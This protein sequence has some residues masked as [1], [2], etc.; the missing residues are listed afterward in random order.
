[1]R[2]HVHAPRF[3][4]GLLVGLDRPAEAAGHAGV[5]DEDV[6]PPA[7]LDGLRDQ[8]P[9]AALAAGVELDGEAVD[10]GGDRRR[11]VDVAVGDD[12]GARAL[13]GQAPRE[14]AADAAA[15]ARHDHVPSGK[16]HRG[17]L[18]VLMGGGAGVIGLDRPAERVSVAPLL[19]ELRYGRELAR[20]AASRLFRS[21]RRREHA[22]PVLLVPGFMAGDASLAVLRQWLLR[23][24]HRVHTSGIRANV[25][26]A[27]EL[28]GRL[29]EQLRALASETERRVLLSARAAAA[30]SR[31]RWP[32]ASPTP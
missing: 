18:Y 12:D 32:C 30:R 29:A 19:G 14:R 22:P 7:C 9:H 27:E 20:L 6:D 1:M 28:V 31:A 16:L 5:G 15:P 17:V 25:D 8:R 11:P 10:L 26:C 4:P 13:L 23:R 24:G 3:V 2:H 21:V